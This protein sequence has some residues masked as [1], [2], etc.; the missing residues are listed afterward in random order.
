MNQR[1]GL[2]NQQTN[3][4]TQGGHFVQDCFVFIC[5]YLEPDFISTYGSHFHIY[6]VEDTFA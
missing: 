4:V 5:F 2:T 6:L 3:T 1:I